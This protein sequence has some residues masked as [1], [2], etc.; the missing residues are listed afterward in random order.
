MKKLRKNFSFLIFKKLKNI[1]DVS[2]LSDVII[3]IYNLLYRINVL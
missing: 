3:V 2:T 1:Y